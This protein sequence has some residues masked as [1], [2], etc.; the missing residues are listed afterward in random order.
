MASKNPSYEKLR[1]EFKILPTT[2]AMCADFDLCTLERESIFQLK[3]KLM[4]KFELVLDTFEHIIQP[5]PDS[6]S[7]MYEFRAFTDGDKKQILD[8]F[9]QLMFHYRAC[10]E[11]EL[12]DEKENAR[13]IRASFDEWQ[14]IKKQVRP[15]FKKLKESWTEKIEHKEILEYLG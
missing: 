14:K 2:E 12:M 6:L 8:L 13:V 9:Q 1:E 10:L 7:D 4:D 15:F 3:R 11:A 5:S